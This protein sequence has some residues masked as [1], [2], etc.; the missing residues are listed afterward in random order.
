LVF[1]Q[2]S[3]GHLDELMQVLSQWVWEPL[4]EP[5]VDDPALLTAC[6]QTGGARVP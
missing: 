1:V 6:D 5:V 3:A 2:R 4:G